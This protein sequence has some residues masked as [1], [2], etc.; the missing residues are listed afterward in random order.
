MSRTR[1]K[2]RARDRLHEHPCIREHPELPLPPE[3]LKGEKSGVQ[4]KRHALQM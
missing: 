1:E 2:L 3:R 4:T